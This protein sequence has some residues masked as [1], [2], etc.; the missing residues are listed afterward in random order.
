MRKILYTFILVMMG[1]GAGSCSLMHDDLPSCDNGIMTLPANDEDPDTTE[2]GAVDLTFDYTY[3]LVR[4]DLFPAHVGAVTVYAY[5]AEGFLLQHE[6]SNLEGFGLDSAGY[7]MHLDL[8]VGPYT[9]V[10]V[11]TQAASSQLSERG[12]AKFR[13]PE[14]RVF[15]YLSEFKV[16]LDRDDYGYVPNEGLHLDTLW[17]GHTDAQ[18]TVEKNQT[19]QA[20]ISLTRNTKRILLGMHNLDDP[21]DIDVDDYRVTIT[22]DNGLTEYDNTHPADETLTYTPHAQWMT[23]WNDGDDNARAA[24]YELSTGR[25]ILYSDQESSRNARLHIERTSDGATIADLNLPQILQQGRGAYET[26][27]YSPQEYLDRAYDFSLDFFVKGTKL[28]YIDLT[29]SNLSWSKRIQYVS[30]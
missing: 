11:G 30:F 20:H 8:P 14:P 6:E 29:V 7:K 3:N 2:W 18:L 22:A 19:T 1:A 4:A 17:M 9:L 26:Q 24:H 21:A 23:D 10:A 15:E 25:L 16:R 12:G 13:L 5:D 27:N 28:Q